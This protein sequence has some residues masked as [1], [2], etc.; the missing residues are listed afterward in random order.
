MTVVRIRTSA[1]HRSVNEHWTSSN[2]EAIDQ[3]FA[4]EQRAYPTGG[5]GISI[6]DVRQD[7]TGLLWHAEFYRMTSCD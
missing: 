3:E 5:Y 4:S 7:P 1:T 6:R 2:R